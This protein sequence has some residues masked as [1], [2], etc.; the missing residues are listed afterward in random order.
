MP[1]IIAL[2][3]GRRLIGVEASV[4]RDRV[5]VRRTLEL[6]WPEELDP[7]DDADAAGA[8]LGE[9][10]RSAG[11]TART[12]VVNVPRTD[13]VVRPLELPLVSDDELPEMVRWQ[14]G[15]RSSIS[16]DEML[17][18]FLPLPY[19]EDAE[20]RDVVVATIPS[21]LADSVRATLR[22]AGIELTSLGVSAMGLADVAGIGADSATTLVAGCDHDRLELA[23][24][25][26]GRAVFT[27]AARLSDEGDIRPMIRSEISRALFA[28]GNQFGGLDVDIA[29][30][31]GTRAELLAEVLA[32]RL[33]DTGDV[34]PV[35]L[36]SPASRDDVEFPAEQSSRDE[37]LVVAAAVGLLLAGTDR[38]DDRIDFLNPHRPPPPKRLWRSKPLIGGL[39]AAVAVVGIIAL[40]QH[41][42]AAEIEREIERVA[43]EVGKKEREVGSKAVESR[44][45]IRK[46]LDQRVD[47][48]AELDEF[49]AIAERDR[50]VLTELQLTQETRQGRPRI[51]ADG[52]AD[53]AS[54]VTA[55]STAFND[56]ER[57]VYEVVPRGA[58]SNADRNRTYSHRFSLEVNLA[59]EVLE[60]KKLESTRVTPGKEVAE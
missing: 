21:D 16:I 1:D 36:F 27:H 57:G 60:F 29:R 18:D 43:I 31:T 35:E 25:R 30:A 52:Q 11:V 24:V 9:Q 45:S 59:D 6:D 44:K 2:D 12:A 40:W 58:Q 19:L 4:T 54:V 8:W 14:A 3:W 48:L 23:V 34:A 10:L 15:T 5:S 53:G 50:V 39:V 51:T 13:A 37:S 42:V 41:G 17:V 7:A 26:D 22:A 32:E 38:V 55:L 49:D 33:A 20:T 56:N 28:V 47:W 46:W